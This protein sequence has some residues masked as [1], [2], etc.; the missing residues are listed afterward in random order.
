M[1]KSFKVLNVNVYSFYLMITIRIE[2]INLKRLK[3]E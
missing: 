3:I 1:L 2:C